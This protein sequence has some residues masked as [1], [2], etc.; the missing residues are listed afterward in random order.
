MFVGGRKPRVAKYWR[1]RRELYVGHAK[2]LISV[3]MVD[4]L[5]RGPIRKILTKYADIARYH[6]D[7]ITSIEILSKSQAI[8][9]G[10]KDKRL[11]VCL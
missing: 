4:Q 3:Y 11:S 6:Q 1:E 7:D 10:G 2:G 9:F 5:N 8:G